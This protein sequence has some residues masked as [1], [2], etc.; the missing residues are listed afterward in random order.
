M[1]RH[2]YGRITMEDVARHA[3]VGTGTL[4][5]HWKTKETLFETV[6]L[7]EL[8]A[9]W[10]ELG[11]RL[12]DAPAD[13]VLHRFL[14]HLLRAVKERPLARA[15]FTRD[16]T[17]LGKLAQ[18]SV[19]LQAQPLASAADLITLLRDLGLMRRDIALHAQAYAFSAVWSGFSLVDPLLTGGDRAPLETQV[20]ALAHVIR[21]T[22]EPD[23]LPDEATVQSEIVPALQAFLDQARAALEQQIQGRMLIP[24]K[25]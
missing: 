8:V 3:G 20:V 21:S 24:N 4:Y 14:G 13:A 10:T 2:G 23:P 6:L 15:L 16:S 1:L 9:I 5:L 11:Q 12:A 17:L 25:G 7:R 22:F 18:R 19:V